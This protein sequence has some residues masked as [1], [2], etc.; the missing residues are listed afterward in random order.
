LGR[1]QRIPKLCAGISVQ[2]V[3]AGEKKKV[4][5]FIGE[6]PLAGDIFQR[7]ASVLRFSASE[8][9]GK[10]KRA[11]FEEKGKREGPEREKRCRKK[12][13]ILG[14]AKHAEGG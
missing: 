14:D 5:D 7:G 2:G 3:G 1:N 9:P 13:G 10:G 12:R 11:P 8:T 6:K 4:L